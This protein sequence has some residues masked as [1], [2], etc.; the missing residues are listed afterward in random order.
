[1][2]LDVNHSEDFRITYNLPLPLILNVNLAHDLMTDF[3]ME[4]SIHVLQST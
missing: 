3:E 4:T 2:K 1:M